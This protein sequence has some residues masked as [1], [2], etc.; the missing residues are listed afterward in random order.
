MYYASHL[1]NQ[2]HEFDQIDYCMDILHYE[3]NLHK[4]K[5]LKDIEILKAFQQT[6]NDIVN[7]II[8]HTNALY[9][10]LLEQ[11]PAK[12]KKKKARVTPDGDGHG[13][14]KALERSFN[15]FHS[16][17]SKN[18]IRYGCYRNFELD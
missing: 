9:K 2:R 15:I 4:T 12:R 18:T 11:Q 1:L 5:I 6:E 8:P 7:G 14:L 17:S 13:P 3:D 16:A 10:I